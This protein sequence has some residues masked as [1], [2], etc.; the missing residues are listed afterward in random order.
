M[1]PKESGRPNDCK[2]RTQETSKD[3]FGLPEA[4]HQHRIRPAV[5]PMK[6]DVLLG[7]GRAHAS[8]PGNRRLQIVVNVNKNWYNA[9]NSRH[10]KTR[11]TEDI[12]N[13][14]QHCGTE[15][16]RFLRYDGDSSGWI[17]VDDNTARIKV[18]Q[19][20]RYTRRSMHTSVIPTSG[21]HTRRHSEPFLVCQKLARTLTQF[22]SSNGSLSEKSTDLVTGNEM[23]ATLGNGVLSRRDDE[24][25]TSANTA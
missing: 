16:G 5:G 12:V 13:Q 18:S 22:P 23:Y 1:I 17:E 14:I 21:E 10:E 15:T 2:K 19:A 7:R 8:H 20:L 9:S 24:S 4:E 6:F 11:I 25:W 3:S